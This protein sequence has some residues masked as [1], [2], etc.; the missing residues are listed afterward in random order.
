[1]TQRAERVQRF[2]EWPVVISALLV[3]PAIAIEQSSLSS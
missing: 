3:L 2:F 1:V